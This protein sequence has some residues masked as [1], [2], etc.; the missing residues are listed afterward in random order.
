MSWSVNIQAAGA[1]EP[2]RS[3]VHLG[4]QAK[5]CGNT[6][7][8][9]VDPQFSVIKHLRDELGLKKIEIALV[10]SICTVFVTRRASE[11]FILPI[12]VE[13]RVWKDF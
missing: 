9:W 2:H 8:S 11:S 10:P 13:A 6:L 5:R 3:F 4:L 1:C 12:Q 7:I